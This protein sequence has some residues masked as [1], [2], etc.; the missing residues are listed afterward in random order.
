MGDCEASTVIW[1]VLAAFLLIL[2][3]IGPVISRYLIIGLGKVLVKAGEGVEMLTEAES[4]AASKS[5]ASA[6]ESS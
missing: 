3:A 5:T 6:T 2:S 4:K 1:I